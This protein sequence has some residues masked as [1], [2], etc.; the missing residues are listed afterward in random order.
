M[1]V[2]ADKR[3][4]QITVGRDPRVT[5]LG[6]WLRKFKIDELPQ[7]VN[8]WK[9]EMSLVGPRPEV[10]HYVAMY[11]QEQARVLELLPGITD[12]A[13]IRYR[14]ESDFLARAADPE[15][16]YIQEIMPHKIRLN[17]EYEAKASI[18]TDFLVIVRTIFTRRPTK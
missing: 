11:S 6:Y 1:V 7:L 8:V 18:W 9:G 13:S 10:P 5:R 2:D 3:G 12:V 16:V 15:R 17:L 4:P 14:N